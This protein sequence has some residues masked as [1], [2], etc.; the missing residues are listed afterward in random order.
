MTGPD[1]LPLVGNQFELKAKSKE[2]GGQQFA[3]KHWMEKYNSPVIGLK[4]G[5]D[6]V[7]VGMTHAIVHEI[8]TRSVFDGRP[9]NF[10]IRLRSMGSKTRLGIT[11]SDGEVWSEQRNFVMKH[12]RIAGYGRAAM[13]EQ[14]QVELD[15]LLE[16]IEQET[17]DEKG[18]WPGELLPTSVLNVLWTFLAGQKI[19]RSDNRL[20]R[21]LDLMKM[22]SRAFDM[23]GGWLTTMPFL[24][25]IAPEMTKY[26][27]ILQFNKEIRAFFQEI[28]DEHKLEY[29]EDRLND[30]LIFAYLHEMKLQEGNS[31]NF[32]ES[33]LMMIILD[34]FLGGSHTTAITLDLA[35]M[36]MV[37]NPH[38]QK[39]AHAEIDEVLGS[40]QYPSLK[41]K[42]K[43]V[44][45]EAILHE[46]MS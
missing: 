21:L 25:F 12:L 9:D 8:H 16:L 46:G 26:N 17:D 33:Q 18:F 11:G 32:S 23:S 38:I 34:L 35:L 28:I 13:E 22:R 27:L 4:L 42:S 43:L 36:S 19:Q 44:Y 24:R 6:L 41:D 40:A 5:N 29:S 3:F 7:V 1:W 20:L 31:T 10:F 15:G 39:R 14:I 37:L 45:I 2:L 30:D